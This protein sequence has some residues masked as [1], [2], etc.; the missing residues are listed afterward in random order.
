[1][2]LFDRG[3]KSGDQTGRS[4]PWGD[5]QKDQVMGRRGTQKHE[6]GKGGRH[7][8]WWRRTSPPKH[9]RGKTSK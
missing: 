8:S 7:R 9:G 3:N 1:M 5:A 6:G 2:G 4:M